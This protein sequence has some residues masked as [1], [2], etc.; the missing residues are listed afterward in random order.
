[1]LVFFEVVIGAVVEV[2][3]SLLTLGCEGG[4]VDVDADGEDWGDED[5]GEEDKDEDEVVVVAVTE[6]GGD[7][8]EGVEDEDEPDEPDGEDEDEDGVNKFVLITIFEKSNTGGKL[9]S[10]GPGPIIG[11]L[12]IFPFDVWDVIGVDED[13][14]EAVGIFFEVGA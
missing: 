6:A 1:M 9:G 13:E 12:F 8:Y 14:G 3:P 2:L 11:G 7:E 5:E 10:V 4:G